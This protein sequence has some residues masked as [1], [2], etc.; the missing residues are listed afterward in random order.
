MASYT[1][2]AKGQNLH[3]AF[4]Q[5]RNGYQTGLPGHTQQLRTLAQRPIGG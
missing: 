5:V 4:E 2:T 3:Q 1:D